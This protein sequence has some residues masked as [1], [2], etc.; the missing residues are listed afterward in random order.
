M[1]LYFYLVI[2]S[3]RCCQGVLLPTAEE[4]GMPDPFGLPTSSLLPNALLPY[5]ILMAPVKCSRRKGQA[6][7]PSLKAQHG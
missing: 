2:L 1:S 3:N 7:G 5:S 4:A 6:P